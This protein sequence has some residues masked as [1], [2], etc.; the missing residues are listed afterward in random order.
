M[1]TASV[2]NLKSQTLGIIS[3]WA[4]L[5]PQL[6]LL[7]FARPVLCWKQAQI[8]KGVNTLQRQKDMESEHGFCITPDTAQRLNPKFPEGATHRARLARITQEN[9]ALKLQTHGKYSREYATCFTL[10]KAAHFHISVFGSYYLVSLA[11]R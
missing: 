2:G 3:P 9:T 6:L 10:L 1:S 4:R 7:K 5:L 11:G 8:W